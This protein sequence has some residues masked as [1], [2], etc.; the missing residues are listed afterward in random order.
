MTYPLS[1]RS[2]QDSAPN[3]FPLTEFEPL[4]DAIEAAALLRMHPKSL[5]KKARSGEIKAIRWGKC[6]H[7]RVS[8]LNEWVWSQQRAPYGAQVI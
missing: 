3:H 8:D 5:K 2:T 6:W 4:L 1:S 7:F